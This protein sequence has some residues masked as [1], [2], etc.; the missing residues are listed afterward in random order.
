MGIR[1]SLLLRRYVGARAPSFDSHPLLG[2][3]LRHPEQVKLSKK[4]RQ[5]TTIKAK[6]EV[7]C[8]S[9]QF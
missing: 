1:Y 9:F 7:S 3:A 2:V 8:R 4:Q 5:E 6:I